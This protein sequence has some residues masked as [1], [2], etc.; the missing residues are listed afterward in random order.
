VTPPSAP[1]SLTAVQ[2]SIRGVQLSWLAPSSTGGAASVTYNVYR[3]TS[4][5]GESATPIAT[6]L[7]ST[8]YLDNSPSLVSGRKYYYK[9]AAVNSAGRGPYSNEAS[10]KAR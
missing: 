9:V 8:S 3:G 10:A 4:P 7:T 2:A 5:G 1:R 6:A